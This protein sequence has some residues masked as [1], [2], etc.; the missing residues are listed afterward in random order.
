MTLTALALAAMLQ[1]ATA[2]EVY[3][4][5][6]ANGTVEY[7]DWACAGT[8]GEKFEPK[9]NSYAAG[10]DLATIRAQNAAFNARQAAK[11]RAIDQANADRY[12]A[13]ES[14]RQQGY[15][16]YLAGQAFQSD[17]AYYAPAYPPYYH[18]GRPRKPVVR[19]VPV[20]KPPPSVPA[21]RPVTPVPV[22]EPPQLNPANK[23]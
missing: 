10:A 13:N 12:L 16:D 5:Q 2:T 9:D 4:C 15:Q 7:R 18:S 23:R 22:K 3:K 20:M 21:K 6:N 11:Q 17:N 8:A 1:S 14:L 19:P